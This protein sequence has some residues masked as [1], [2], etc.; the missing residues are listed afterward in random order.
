MGK[1][2]LSDEG[3]ADES[4]DRSIS[5]SFDSESTSGTP[6]Q[7]QARPVTRPSPGRWQPGD[8]YGMSPISFM[9]TT[10]DPIPAQRSLSGNQIGGRRSPAVGSPEKSTAGKI[11]PGKSLS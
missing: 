11:D 9:L 3:S 5:E 1:V 4:D 7:T 8:T 2:C 6:A 10:D